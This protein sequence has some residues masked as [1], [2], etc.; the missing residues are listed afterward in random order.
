MKIELKD[1]MDK[2]EMLS[3]IFLGCIPK[4]KLLKIKKYYIGEK[5]W[6]KESMKIPVEMTIGGFSINPK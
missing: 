6:K 1:L 2:N 4:D 3:H 5:N